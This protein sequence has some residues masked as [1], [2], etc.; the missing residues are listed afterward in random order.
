ME[1]KMGK[2]SFNKCKE[3]FIIPQQENISTNGEIQ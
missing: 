1:R 2:Y 3:D